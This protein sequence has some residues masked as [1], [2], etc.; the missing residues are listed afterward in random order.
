MK[1]PSPALPGIIS[2][3]PGIPA[4]P[5]SGG[6]R[7]SDGLHLR[8]AIPERMLPSVVAAMAFLAALAMAGAIGAHLLAERWDAGAGA[9]LTVQVPDPAS[10]AAIPGSTRIDAVMARLATLPGLL[11]VRR[12]QD[13]ELQ[14]LL[15]P[16]LDVASGGDDPPLPLPAVVQ[17]RLAPGAGPPPQLAESLRDTAPGTLVENSARWSG[18]LLALAAS[19]Q[20]C[21]GLALLMV[22]AVAGCVVALATRMGIAMRRQAIE[23]LHGLGA[24]DGY[25]A[26]R[27][28][29]RAGR[30]ALVGGA[31][32]AVLALPFLASLSHL[33]APFASGHVTPESLP[34]AAAVA[35]AGAGARAG[36]GGGLTPA[37]LL[38]DRLPLALL[39]ALPGL[40]VAAGLIGWLT[41][42]GT[43]RVWLRR[44][45]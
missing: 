39:V 15:Q 18:S 7:G 6:R 2:A 25:I 45:P 3:P 14:R 28:A 41:A 43:V 36:D 4:R 42:Q 24:S 8:A 23:L 17:L 32:G 19:L 37:S 21:A 16:W 44:L 31:A 20:A 26:G 29:R 11:A 27:F 38:P 10:A 35:E 40:P 22:A 9:L 1:R 5:G 34:G 33:A 30:L 12:L 13:A